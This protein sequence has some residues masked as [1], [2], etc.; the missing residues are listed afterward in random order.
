MKENNQFWEQRMDLLAQQEY[1]I[2]DNFF[3][4]KELF[5]IHDFFQQKEEEGVFKKAAVGTSGKEKVI[6]EIRGDYTYWLD[7]ERDQFQLPIYQTLD[8]IKN[9][10]N[11]LLFLSLSDYEFHLAHYPTGSFYKK[12]LDQ[13]NHRSN[14]MISMIVYL[15]KGWTPTDGGEL[16]VYPKD[17]S[18]IAIE[19]IENRCVLFRSDTLYHEVLLANKSRRSLTGWMLHQPAGLTFLG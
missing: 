11:E 8:L 12:H 4:K 19:P 17:S 3:S 2:T 18:P 15:N 14:R 9:K 13:F 16:C 1:V 7:K 6:N 10:L 5:L